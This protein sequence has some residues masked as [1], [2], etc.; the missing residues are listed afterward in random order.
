VGDELVLEIETRDPQRDKLISPDLLVDSALF[1][2]SSSWV[3]LDPVE[4]RSAKGLEGNKPVY[5]YRVETDDV[6]WLYLKYNEDVILRY[7]LNIKKK[8][9]A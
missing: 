9:P 7:K 1:N 5:R 8:K 6:E 2:Y 4:Y 3:F